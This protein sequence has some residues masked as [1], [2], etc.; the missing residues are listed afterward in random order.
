MIYKVISKIL[1]NWLGE[2]ILGIISVKQSVFIPSRFITD[3]IAVAHEL[4]HSLQSRQKG[5]Q[6]HMPLS[7]T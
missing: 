7:F 2:V 3:S 4:L 1:T 6:Y 5:K